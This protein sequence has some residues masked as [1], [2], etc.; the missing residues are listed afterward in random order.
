MKKV[1]FLFALALI[2]LASTPFIG[3]IR[4]NISGYILNYQRY[5]DTVNIGLPLPAEFYDKEIARILKDTFLINNPTTPL[6]IQALALRNEQTTYRYVNEHNGDYSLNVSVGYGLMPGNGNYWEDISVG[7]GEFLEETKEYIMHKLIK[8][9]FAQTCL[10][11]WAKPT[12]IAAW[13]SKTDT[14][15]AMDM[16]AV[17][18]AGQYLKQYDRQKELK[19]Q[20]K[21]YT[22]GFAKG[23]NSFTRTDWRGKDDEDAKIYA[24]WHRRISEYTKS[25]S[26]FS[27]DDARYWTKIAFSN[28]L[29]NAKP[30]AKIA[31]NDWKQLWIDGKIT[32][33]PNCRLGGACYEAHEGCL[34]PYKHKDN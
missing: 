24:F 15:Q 3:G 31:F 6:K 20:K 26:G 7:R 11:D 34:N 14:A 1:I 22:S 8:D 4:E 13:V 30:T 5:Y 18:K 23:Y 28:M 25:G 21:V 17:W 29:D 16:F 19:R 33:V 9:R 10:Y 32:S 12:I 27:L 2:G